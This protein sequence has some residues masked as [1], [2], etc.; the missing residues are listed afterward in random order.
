MTYTSTSITFKQPHFLPMKNGF[1]L[2]CT[3]ITSRRAIDADFP[4]SLLPCHRPCWLPYQKI[5]AKGLRSSRQHSAMCQQTHPMCLTAK[6]Q[7]RLRP[8]VS[9]AHRTRPRPRNGAPRADTT[10]TPQTPLHSSLPMVRNRNVGN[11]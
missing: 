5:M 7:R 10:H 6:H 8:R 4:H 3:L 1:G 2:V 9:P 11:L